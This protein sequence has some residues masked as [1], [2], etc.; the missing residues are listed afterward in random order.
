ARP[1]K[2]PRQYARSSPRLV[3]QAPN[4]FAAGARA[5]GPE[6]PPLRA[7]AGD[8][9]DEMRRAVGEEQV[10]AAG[11]VTG[12]VVEAAVGVGL[13]VNPV[14]VHENQ[15]R[16]RGRGRPPRVARPGPDHDAARGAGPDAQGVRPGA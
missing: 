6:G 16:G 10:D 7:V 8:A 13:D 5:E 2:G 1:S 14:V 3:V 4:D 11:V 9:A 12:E 15:A